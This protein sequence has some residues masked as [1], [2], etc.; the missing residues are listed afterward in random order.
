MISDTRPKSK[1][2]AGIHV[3]IFKLPPRLTDMLCRYFWK[4]AGCW[5]GE[6]CPFLHEKTPLPPP[7]P[8]N[9]LASHNSGLQAPK[10]PPLTGLEVAEPDD[11]EPQAVEPEE[12]VEGSPA[13]KETISKFRAGMYVFLHET[14]KL[15]KTLLRYFNTTVG[16]LKGDSC[17][18]LHRRKPPPPLAEKN[19]PTITYVKHNEKTKKSAE[20]IERN[21]PELWTLILAERL[22]VSEQEI[23]AARNCNCEEAQDRDSTYIDES[24]R[25]WHASIWSAFTGCLTS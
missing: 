11:P 24:V 16:C 12:S 23:E 8:S 3:K 4:P 14:F 17:S 7:S 18:Y 20:N 1:P 19:V 6:Y 22:R 15:T 2:R 9:V 21:D 10:L 5:K 13:W 25:A